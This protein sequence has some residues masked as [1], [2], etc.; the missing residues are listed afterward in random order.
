M[1]SCVARRERASR[2]RSESPPF[3]RRAKG[4]TADERAG[5]HLRAA[6]GFRRATALLRAAAADPRRDDATRALLA[7]RA[8][9]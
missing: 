5:E 8:D 1:A 6:D 3:T 9:E 7:E 4:A 2:D